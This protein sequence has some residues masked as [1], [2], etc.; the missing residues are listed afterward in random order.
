MLSFNNYQYV[1]SE[2]I[3]IKKIGHMLIYKMKITLLRN[4]TIKFMFLG[5]G[6]VSVMSSEG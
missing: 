1:C 6:S 4:S 2:D 5:L 3:T